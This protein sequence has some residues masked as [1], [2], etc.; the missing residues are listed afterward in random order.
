MSTQWERPGFYDLTERDRAIAR[1]LGE[2]KSVTEV[3]ERM[4][5]SYRRMVTLVTDICDKLGLEGSYSKTLQL[6]YWARETFGKGDPE[7]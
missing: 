3:A 6:R 4:G 7:R 1:L 5:L 2:G